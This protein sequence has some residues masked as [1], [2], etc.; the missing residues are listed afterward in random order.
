MK[1][2]RLRWLGRRINHPWWLLMSHRVALVLMELRCTMRPVQPHPFR[3]LPMIVITVTLLLL[4][5]L[6]LFHEYS[7]ERQG[8]VQKISS[9]LNYHIATELRQ[10][11]SGLHSPCHCGGHT[12][13]FEQSKPYFFKNVVDI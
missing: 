1:V 6:L 5:L 10:R 3:V 4:V 7:D 13:P 11:Q 9:I 12:G 2:R 8:D